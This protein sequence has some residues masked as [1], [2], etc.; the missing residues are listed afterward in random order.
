MSV[1]SS[2]IF[3]LL[4]A[5]VTIIVSH[6][7]SVP[8]RKHRGGKSRPTAGPFQNCCLSA[9]AETHSLRK[10]RSPSKCRDCDSYVYF[11]GAECHVCGVTC[12]KKCLAKLSIKCGNQV[13]RARVGLADV[14]QRRHV[15]SYWPR[16]VWSASFNHSALRAWN[17]RRLFSGNTVDLP[18]ETFTGKHVDLFV[19]SGTA[20]S[21]SVIVSSSIIEEKRSISKFVARRGLLAVSGHRDVITW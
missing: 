8:P 20:F 15:T 10:L 1:L 12:H 19:L 5:V 9:A 2:L 4:H 3:V 14:P 7:P 21:T 16:V 11:N 6:S 13:G 17:P 18:S